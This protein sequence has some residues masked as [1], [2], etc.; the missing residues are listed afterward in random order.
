MIIGGKAYKRVYIYHPRMAPTVCS[1][2]V[3]QQAGL[4]SLSVTAV[5]GMR[6]TVRLDEVAEFNGSARHGLEEPAPVDLGDVRNQN[7]LY[8]LVDGAVRLAA[9]RNGDVKLSRGAVRIIVEGEKRVYDSILGLLKRTD[10]PDGR[11]PLAVVT[12]G[13][14]LEQLAVVEHVQPAPAF[15]YSRAEAEL[16]TVY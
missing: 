12:G 3:W 1:D 9:T 11:R 10:V 15:A 5:D 13:P 6:C 8:R 2:G 7:A 4:V 16:A 14:T